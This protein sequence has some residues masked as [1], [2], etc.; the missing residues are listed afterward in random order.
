MGIWCYSTSS[1]G[2]PFWSSLVPIYGPH[3]A[4]TVRAVLCTLLPSLWTHN[5]P[6]HGHEM[7]PIWGPFEVPPECALLGCRHM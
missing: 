5:G 6:K 2:V 1:D 7:D 3:M 4:P